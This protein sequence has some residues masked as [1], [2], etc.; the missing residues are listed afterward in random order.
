MKSAQTFSDE[1]F[2][3]WET[4]WRMP[5]YFLFF[6]HSALCP[7]TCYKVVYQIYI[8]IYK[9][10]QCINSVLYFISYSPIC[11][12]TLS[13]QRNQMY[14]E[15][16]WFTYSGEFRHL[17]HH[18]YGIHISKTV[19]NFTGKWKIIVQRLH[20]GWVYSRFRLFHDQSKLRLKYPVKDAEASKVAI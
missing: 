6:W 5:W 3:D 2:S 16:I 8:Q 19:Q 1:G 7:I 13:T 9:I 20:I 17:R 12:F 14:F 11:Q 10:K 15:Y 18:D 4:R